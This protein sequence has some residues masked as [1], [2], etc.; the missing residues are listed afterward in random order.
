[1]N[2]VW[3]SRCRLRGIAAACLFLATTAHAACTSPTAAEGSLDYNASSHYFQYCD[4]TSTWQP[5]VSGGGGGFADHII[6][7]TTNIYV[8]SASS[9][10]S[11]TTNGSVANYFDSQGR[12]I[13]TGISVTSPAPNVSA[14]FFST[15]PN[16][17]PRLA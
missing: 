6:S 3:S 7:G 4:N 5:L 13:T 16:D 12:L 1:M 14:E 9:Y 2:R 8:N 17:D 11:F 10:I 15:T